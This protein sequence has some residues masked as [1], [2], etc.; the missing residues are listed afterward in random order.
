MDRYRRTRSTAADV[1]LCPLPELVVPFSS[2]PRR[3]LAVA[4][5]HWVGHLPGGR[6][7]EGDTAEKKALAGKLWGAEISYLNY[8]KTVD[9]YETNILRNLRTR[10]YD[11]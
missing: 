11:C 3:Q 9:S 7:R 6:G 10:S 4:D 2:N 1:R 8:R 5:Y